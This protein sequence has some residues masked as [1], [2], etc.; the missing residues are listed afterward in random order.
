MFPIGIHCLMS[1][2][3][4]PVAAEN[5]F[6]TMFQYLRNEGPSPNIRNQC[7][8]DSS[9][10]HLL[11]LY[12]SWKP[13]WLKGLRAVEFGKFATFPQNPNNCPLQSTESLSKEE[14]KKVATLIENAPGKARI[15]P[16]ISPLPSADRVERIV[17]TPS[18]L[19]N[20]P[21]KSPASPAQTPMGFLSLGDQNEDFNS[22]GFFFPIEFTF[23]DSERNQ[24]ISDMLEN[25]TSNEFI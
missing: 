17:L 23:P 11:C 14:T 21:E 7:V 22:N 25:L 13:S 5:G 24:A 6:M 19:A 12:F 15:E 3:T 8:F 10:V 4:N 9:L 1:F 18:S 2:F 20:E 16:I